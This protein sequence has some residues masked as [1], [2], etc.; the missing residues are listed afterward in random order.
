MQCREDKASADFTQL[1]EV[2][3]GHFG[4]NPFEA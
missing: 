2:I 3:S 1:V 4:V